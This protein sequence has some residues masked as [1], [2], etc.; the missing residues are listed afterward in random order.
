M[1]KTGMVVK[2]TGN[3]CI[4]LTS[5]GE[6]KKVSLP[7]NSVTRLGQII[8]DEER[9][10][11]F[12]YLRHFMVAASLLLLVLTG[13]LYLGRSKPASAFM[14][15]DI[16]PS[17]ELAIQADKR[18]ASARGLNSDG[19]TILNEV[20]VTGLDLHEAAKL[21]VD[22]AIKD[23]FLL[24]NDNNIILVTLTT[25]DIEN[26]TDELESIYESINSP[27]Q[28]N[29]LDTEVIIE[30]VENTV[31]QEAEKAGISTGRYLLLQKSAAKGVPVNV[32]EISVK[33]LRELE[34]DKK[35]SISEILSDSSYKSSN[36][37]GSNNDYYRYYS[38]NSYKS[39]NI[40]R[41]FGDRNDSEA[42]FNSFRKLLEKNAGMKNNNNQNILEKRQNTKEDYANKKN[43]NNAA[44]REKTNSGNDKKTFPRQN[45]EKKERNTDRTKI[46]DFFQNH[47]RERQLK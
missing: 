27:V 33:S 5:D 21:I 15:I 34:K 17:I 24:A 40:N 22:Q 25:D 43:D 30:P 44:G 9:K 14:T 20:K 1:K 8:T 38:N 4:L 35:I 41:N 29:G 2:I 16:N 18:I 37:Y 6:Y 42:G 13:Q 39:N 7:E 19:A 46:L 3:S 28:S 10:K 26:F 45:G 11:R 47:G 12:P 32:D 36:R 23:Q 31:R